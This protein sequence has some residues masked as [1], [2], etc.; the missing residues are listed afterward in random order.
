M[1]CLLPIFALFVPRVLMVFIFLLTNCFG[2]S[3]ETLIWPLVGFFFMPYT[4]L[5][6]MAA[7]LNNNHQLSGGW[8][9][10]IIVA[11]FFDLGGQGR[12]TKHVVYYRK[13]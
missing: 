2:R 7:M 12:S 8:I 9:V 13:R 4:T 1:G 3:Y 5:A 11:V 10:L 6:Y